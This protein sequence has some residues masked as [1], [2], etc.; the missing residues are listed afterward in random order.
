MVCAAWENE[1]P[2]LLIF[3]NCEDEA[4]LRAFRPVTGGSRVLVTSRREQWDA[5]VNVQAVPVGMLSVTDSAALLRKLNPQL[6]CGWR[7]CRDR[8]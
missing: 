1:L 5:S 8:R 7:P 6:P 3:D 4:L 2:R